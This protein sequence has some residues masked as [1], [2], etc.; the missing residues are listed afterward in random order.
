VTRYGVRELNR[1]LFDLDTSHASPEQR[2]HALEEWSRRHD[3]QQRRLGAVLTVGSLTVPLAAAGILVLVT[4][5]HLAAGWWILAGWFGVLLA[6]LALSLYAV[7]PS[8]ERSHSK[9]FAI[10]ERVSTFVAPAL[11]GCAYFSQVSTN[12]AAWT[13]AAAIGAIAHLAWFLPNVLK[14]IARRRAQTPIYPDNQ[15][16]NS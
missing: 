12:S 5:I 4:D 15:G 14:D 9:D 2:H 8:R 16:G 13:I 7:D 10:Q 11:G 6:A 1:L 3:R